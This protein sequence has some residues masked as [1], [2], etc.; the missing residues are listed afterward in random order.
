MSFLTSSAVIVIIAC[1]FY[2][3]V[4]AYQLY[5]RTPWLQ[6]RAILGPQQKQMYVTILRICSL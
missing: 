6:L 5:H 4:T 1:F 2:L 3:M